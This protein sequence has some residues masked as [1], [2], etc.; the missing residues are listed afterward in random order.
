MWDMLRALVAAL[1]LVSGQPLGLQ[2]RKVT[3]GAKPVKTDE[4]EIKTTPQTG[5]KVNSQQVGPGGKTAPVNEGPGK[6]PKESGGTAPANGFGAA[7][8]TPGFVTNVY[9]EASL[10]AVFNEVGAIA[11]VQIIADS[12]VPDTAVTIEFKNE[13]IDAVV[14]KLALIGGLQ[15]KK[16]GDL[17]L[18][19]VAAPDSPLYNEFSVTR[20]FI[21]QNVPVESLLAAMPQKWKELVSGDKSTNLMTINASEDTADRILADLRVMDKAPRQIVVEALITEIN[22]SK[23]DDFN[24]S[25][26][27]HNFGAD[28]NLLL[29]YSSTQVD[30]LVKLKMLLQ[31]QRATVRANPRVWATEG[32]ETN[33]RVGQELYYALQNSNA[34]TAFNFGQIQQI[35]TGVTLKFTAFIHDDGLITLNLDPEVSDAATYTAQGNPQVNIRTA[36]TT[37]TLRDGETFAIGG[38][39]QEFTKQTVSKVPIIGDIPL[40]GQL[41]TSKSASKQ[42]TEVVMMITPH[43]ANNGAGLT[44]VDSARAVGGLNMLDPNWENGG[45][46]GLKPNF[47]TPDKPPVKA[48]PKVVL[49]N[50]DTMNSVVVAPMCARNLF[51]FDEASS[52]VSMVSGILPAGIAY[53]A[54]LAALPSTKDEN[55]KSMEMLVLRDG[56]GFSGERVSVR[57]IGAILG[58]TMVNG[59]TVARNVYVGVQ[60]NSVKYAGVR[61]LDDLD[62]LKKD[63]L[64]LFLKGFVPAMNGTYDMKQ[65]VGAPTAS[66]WLARAVLRRQGK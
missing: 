58:S 41:F 28:S 52:N 2:G 4:Q 54:D 11:G 56:P 23:G 8:Q 3:S 17:Y 49:P 62:A 53:P 60:T 21:P 1:A 48:A 24:F 26:N 22:S 32:R 13:P 66:E 59:K 18:V 5:P 33:F 43:I 50:V 36:H 20:R 6:D 63:E 44:G 42:K 37:I 30:D 65:M 27:W 14:R 38:L 46:P 9:T 45:H 61:T 39:V 64:G 34:S 25:W 57:P 10:R 55:G 29:Q 12:S 16:K 19:S 31:N 47:N 40:I 51:K 7:A 15:V 35:K